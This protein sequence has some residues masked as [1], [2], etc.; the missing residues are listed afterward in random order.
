MTHCNSTESFS[1]KKMN[2][3][4][5][6]KLSNYFGTIEIPNQ[7]MNFN[8][9]KSKFSFESLFVKNE[10]IEAMNKIKFECNEVVDSKNMFNFNLEGP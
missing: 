6:V 1:V 4:G 3:N 7:N 10:V 8:N 2:E 9:T 5:T